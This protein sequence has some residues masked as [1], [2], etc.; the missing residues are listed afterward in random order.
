M[1]FVSK[2]FLFFWLAVII[3]LVGIISL[4]TLGLKPGI[5]FSSGS[6]LGLRFDNPDVEQRD[7]SQELSSLG[8]DAIVQHTGRDFLVRTHELTAEEKAGLVSALAGRFGNLTE[9]Q[10]ASV[11]PQVAAETVQNAGIA[12]AIASAGILLYITWAFRKMPRPLHYG[13][14]AIISMLHDVFVTLGIFSILGGLLGWQVNLMFITG[15]LAVIGYSVN[16]TVIIYDRIREN[17]RLGISPDFELLV[18]KS[19]V[20]TMGRTLNTS[21]TTLITLTALMLFVG[22]SI[23]NF[24][25]V[26][27]TGIVVGMF[28][29][30]FIAP[31][32]LV[33]WDKSEWGRFVSWIPAFKKA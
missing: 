33:V 8:Y 2:R 19:V 25:V 13:T 21:V 32:L 12:V 16:N 1:D 5:E 9:T 27:M 18:N 10:F 23:Q 30:V 7:L 28:T 11:S 6:I 26:L 24:V 15:V 31:S 3:L 22:S 29:S 4:S 14:S 20:D 17:V